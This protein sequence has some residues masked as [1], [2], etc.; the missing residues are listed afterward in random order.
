MREDVAR[1]D[2]ID[3]ATGLEFDIKGTVLKS[4]APDDWLGPLAQLLLADVRRRRET[5]QQS[6]NAAPP[7]RKVR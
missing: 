1:P 2:V 7:Q 3:T 5:N 4:A 6:D